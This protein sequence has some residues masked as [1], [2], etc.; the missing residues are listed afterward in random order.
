MNAP[1]TSVTTGKASLVG[2][3]VVAAAVLVLWLAVTRE[4]G[5]TGMP[6]LIAGLAMAAAAGIWTRL[7]DL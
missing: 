3:V 7:A 6:A 1:R 2:G 4:L 5:F